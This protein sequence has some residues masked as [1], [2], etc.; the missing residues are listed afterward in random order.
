M[1]KNAG[2][3]YYVEVTSAATVAPADQGE[4]LLTVTAS[5]AVLPPFQVTATTPADGTTSYDTVPSQITVDFN[6]NILL[7]TLQASDLKVNGTPAVGVTAT[8]GDTAVFST[9]YA[10]QWSTSA[11]GNGH[12]Y[13]LTPS[14][15]TWDQEEAQAVALGGHL[16]SLTNQAEQ[17][18]I[19]RTFLSDG[20]R[21]R[22]LWS[23]LND[24][25]SEGNFVW[26][27]GD[28]VSYTN[29]SPGEPNGF[30]GEN[31]IAMNW[32]FGNYQTNDLNDRGKWVDTRDDNYG[33]LLQGVIELNALPAGYFVV[34]D[35]VNQV[36]IAAGAI[37]DVQGTP[38]QA[39]N[40]S[41][42]L[43]QTAPRV[44]DSSLQP[45]A[46][47]PAGSLTWTV[48]FSEPINTGNYL[49]NQIHAVGMFRG[50]N[51][52]PSDFNWD[53]TGTVLSIAFN[54]LPDDRYTL[55]LDANPGG[56][57][58]LHG[59]VLD[60]ETFV[61]GVSQWPIPDGHSG[62]GVEGGSF[63]VTVAMDVGTQ[64][65][66]VPL[67]A[68][69]PL[70]SLIYQ[71]PTPATGTIAFAGDIDGF[72]IDLDAGQVL[73]VDAGALTADLQPT[74]SVT[75]PEWHAPWQYRRSVAG[76]RG[77]SP[78]SASRHDRDLYDYGRRPLWLTGSL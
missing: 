63:S 74:V 36:S 31:Y 1:P 52:G 72:T 11:G 70:G 32:V 57:E 76:E 35:G 27:N 46:Q 77:H 50:I 56:F 22:I 18:F 61:N 64:T 75:R 54:N 26:S 24:A 62:D 5:T 67:V 55:S 15:G 45:D 40:G 38:I 19:N 42:V 73:A 48:T 66:P 16:V 12:Y 71:S 29:L 58:D 39:Y 47:L 8:D 28:P 7:S 10:F 25:A 53:S 51:V 6:D 43:D 37:K 41:F 59:L 65:L 20:E 9:P 17:D 21:R 78:G 3:N 44:I 60:G 2:G 68:V 69:Q 4:Y 34:H 13:L 14:A 30:T 49:W 23:G 33:N